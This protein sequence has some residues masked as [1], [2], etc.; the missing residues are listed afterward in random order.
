ME[1]YGEGDNEKRACGLLGH[2]DNDCTI[3]SLGSNNEWGFEEEIFKRT[4]CK[5][6]TFD[7][8][9][10]NNVE[11]PEAIRSRVT[12]HKVCVGVEDKIIGGLKF[13]TWESLLALTGTASSPTFLK[14]DI[15]GFEWE[16]L[17]HIINKDTSPLQISFE[18]HYQT[19][20]KELAWQRNGKN[21]EDILLFF[22]A[23]YEKGGYFVIDRHDNDRCEHCTELL[24]SKVCTPNA[25]T[26][27]NKK[28]K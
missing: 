17:P 3:I 25:P 11:P 14:M 1:H 24:V 8:T 2:V 5:V 26:T 6:H 7:C 10:A 12:L 9:V 18:L 27:K 23:L 21:A 19:Q 22:D 28:I 20:M 4:S 16:V 15:E 13:V